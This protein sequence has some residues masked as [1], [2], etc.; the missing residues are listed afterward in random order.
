MTIDF[1]KLVVGP[2]MNAFAIGVV[3]TPPGQAPLPQS[4]GVWSYRTSDVILEDGS[5]L[6]TVDI[7]LGIWGSEYPV[8]PQSGW[9]MRNTV[10]GSDYLVDAVIP[11]GQ[12]GWTVRLKAL[13]PVLVSG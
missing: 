12:G 11:D 8:M 9:K 5:R 4:R 1:G 6:S 3:F 13:T 2:A 7:S 10:N